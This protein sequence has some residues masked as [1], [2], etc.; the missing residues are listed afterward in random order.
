MEWIILIIW[1][2]WSK[3]LFSK[4]GSSYVD[5]STLSHPLTFLTSYLMLI[6]CFVLR[7][8]AEFCNVCAF[9]VS[10]LIALWTALKLEKHSF[11]TVINKKNW[12]TRG[13]DC[14]GVENIKEGCSPSDSALQS[15]REMCKITFL[16][17]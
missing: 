17:S 4:P 8:H 9:Y 14:R 5:S 16:L 3:W 10:E 13:K 1:H 12:R 15:L 6:L 2:I 7:C 11:S